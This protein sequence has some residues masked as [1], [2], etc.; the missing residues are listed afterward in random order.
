MLS[1][2]L[3][4]NSL[5]LDSTNTCLFDKINT[6]LTHEKSILK[7]FIATLFTHLQFFVSPP[8]EDVPWA[9]FV[10][11]QAFLTMFLLIFF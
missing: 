4:R 1:F 8:E 10:V 5:V 3:C 7:G 6:T 2:D 9:A 11:F